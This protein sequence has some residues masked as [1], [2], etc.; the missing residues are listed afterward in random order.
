MDQIKGKLYR[1]D[2][3]DG[4]FYIGSTRLSLQKRFWC[5]K[6]DAKKRNSK[7]YQHIN[8]VGWDAV[9]ISLIDELICNSIQD[10]RL[11]ENKEIEKYIL[12]PLCLNTRKCFHN[13][14]EYYETN[15]DKICQYKKDYYQR[16]KQDQEK[17]E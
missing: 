10:L 17:I 1:L 2:A 3:P 8:Q 9:K 5:H 13:Q 7:L 6:E 11:K 16:K 14:K 15:K 4:S 12:D